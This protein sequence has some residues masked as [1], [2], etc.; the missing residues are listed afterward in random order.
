M[1]ISHLHISTHMKQERGGRKKGIF[2]WKNKAA[3]AQE[4][5]RLAHTA[6]IKAQY[7]STVITTGQTGQK[8]R[9]RAQKWTQVHIPPCLRQER[10]LLK[11]TGVEGGLFGVCV[12]VTGFPYRKTKQSLHP[13]PSTKIKTRSMERKDAPRKQLGTHFFDEL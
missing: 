12:G 8:N 5:S 2:V 9:K 3:S 10:T 13:L 7:N 1:H 6:V 11:G 4:Y